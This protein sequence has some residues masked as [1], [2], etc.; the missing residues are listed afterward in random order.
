[1][2]VFCNIVS[3]KIKAR[4]VE[5]VNEREVLAFHDINPQAPVHVVVIPR[6][7]FLASKD[8]DVLATVMGTASEIAVDALGL[9]SFRLVLN[10][11]PDAGQ[12][13]E[14]MHVHIL[15]GKTLGPIA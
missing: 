14:H 8:S 10:C 5:G 7:H 11:G 12:Q 9:S 2:C 15:G 3:G 13:V 1:M 6:G 4:F